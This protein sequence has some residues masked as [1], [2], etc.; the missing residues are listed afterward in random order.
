MIIHETGGRGDLEEK[1][2]WAGAAGCLEH[3]L[4]AVHAKHPGT[5][6]GK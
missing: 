2:F 4:T 1:T 6:Q 3:G 5:T